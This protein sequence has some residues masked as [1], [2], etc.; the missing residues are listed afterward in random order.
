[1]NQR[2]EEERRTHNRLAQRAHQQRVKNKIALLEAKVTRLLEIKYK[3]YPCGKTAADVSPLNSNFCGFTDTNQSRTAAIVAEISSPK[4]P[5]IPH[6]NLK[7]LPAID[8]DAIKA[9]P[10]AERRIVQN[11]ISQR[12]L[13]QRRKEKINELQSLI[14]TLTKELGIYS[15]I[16]RPFDTLTDRQK[17]TRNID[18][19][20]HQQQNFFITTTQAENT[21]SFFSSLPLPPLLDFDSYIRLPP[22]RT[23][24]LEK[25]QRDAAKEQAFMVPPSPQQVPLLSA[26]ELHATNAYPTSAGVSTPTTN[27]VT[28]I[29]TNT[30]NNT[31]AAIIAT[32]ECIVQQ[33]QF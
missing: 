30:N 23:V 25:Q 2:V 8:P 28:N 16:S 22:L 3:N 14:M 10:L 17:S 1:M 9:L 11:R 7:P 31:I 29:T 19:Q 32:P 24:V 33:W 4:T 12:A 20:I 6:G 21:N 27:N 15:T 5:A 18:Q 26:A 13:R